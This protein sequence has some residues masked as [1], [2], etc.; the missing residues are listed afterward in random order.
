MRSRTLVSSPAFWRRFDID[1]VAI[2]LSCQ[3]WYHIVP[4][5]LFSGVTFS[6]RERPSYS[7]VPG[8]TNTTSKFHEESKELNNERCN[9]LPAAG[10]RD[11]LG[12]PGARPVHTSAAQ[13][14]RRADDPYAKTGG[15]GRAGHENHARRNSCDRS[16]VSRRQNSAVVHARRRQG[17]DLHTELQGR[18]RGSAPYRKPASV[19]GKPR[20]RAVHSGRATLAARNTIAR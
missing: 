15:Y 4:L 1:V 19:E 18:S 2:T 12:A 10:V 16:P 8:G 3:R 5:S 13:D 14:H 17:R 20:G 6:P 11:G 7:V 9:V